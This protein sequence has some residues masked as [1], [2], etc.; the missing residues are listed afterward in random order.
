MSRSRKKVSTYSNDSEKK[1]KRINNKRL[2]RINKVRLEKGKEMLE[3]KEVSDKWNMG[4]DGLNHML[5]N[6]DSEFYEKGLRK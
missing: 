5:I 2:R 1:D 4:K 3:M 6:K